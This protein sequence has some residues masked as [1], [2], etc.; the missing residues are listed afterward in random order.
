MELDQFRQ[1]N[2]SLGSP[3]AA[4]E[5]QDE[6]LTPGHLLDRYRLVAIIDQREG[7]KLLTK[8]VVECHPKLPSSSA[9]SKSPE[10]QSLAA[11]AHVAQPE[12]P[13]R[14][15]FLSLAAREARG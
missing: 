2:L 15:A 14:C 11:S 1:L 3:G 6:G 10:W 12:R 4:V 13:Q 5:G 9:E 8:A 7:G